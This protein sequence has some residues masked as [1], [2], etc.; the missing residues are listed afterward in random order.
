MRR[1][2]ASIA[3]PDPPDTTPPFPA[4]SA[5]SSRVYRRWLATQ[6]ELKER[7]YARDLLDMVDIV[8]EAAL[9]QEDVS[10]LTPEPLNV[11][12]RRKRRLGDVTMHELRG[13]SSPVEHAADWA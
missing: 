12:P 11:G 3:P 13:A 10:L 2:T 8:V 1:D 7:F 9:E 5:M 6:L 4:Q